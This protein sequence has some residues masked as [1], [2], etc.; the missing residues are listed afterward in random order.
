MK[1]VAVNGSPRVHGNTNY[2]IDEALKEAGKAGIETEK[3]MVSEYKINGCQG[4]DRCKF[5][6]VCPVKDDTAAIYEK[7]YEADGIIL[8]SPVYSLDI[9]AQLKALIDRSRIYRRHGRM[10]KARCAGLIIVAGR[11]GIEET[12]NVMV[13]FIVISSKVPADK[14]MQVSGFAGAEGEVKGNTAF[15]E[16]ARALGRSMAE[17]LLKGSA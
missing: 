15:V 9:T 14:V 3:I 10:M 6:E 17:E 7:I 2:L 12:A 8:G 13:N 11:R 4:H 16:E 5:F 1:I